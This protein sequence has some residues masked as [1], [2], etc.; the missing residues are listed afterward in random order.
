ML[1]PILFIIS[2][3]AFVRADELCG[4]QP[5]GTLLPNK[6]DCSSFW[7]CSH[8]TAWAMKC[9]PG[10]Y[11]D[12]KS[13]RCDY[14]E[15]VECFDGD[16]EEEEEDDDDDDD[17]IQCPGDAEE[18]VLIF[19]PSKK[20]CSIYYVCLDGQLFQLDC[21]DKHW[22]QELEQCVEVEL[23][24]CRVSFSYYKTQTNSTISDWWNRDFHSSVHH[25]TCNFII[26][27]YLNDDKYHKK[28]GGRRRR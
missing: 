2:T 14:E 16:S 25:T 7:A 9:Q 15:N 17:N 18:G 22:N 13:Q 28:R 12:Y 8:G 11:F 27:K 4:S 3:L 5:E 6:E 24:E 1:Y 10:L 23:S 20:S 26:N 19:Y 21:V